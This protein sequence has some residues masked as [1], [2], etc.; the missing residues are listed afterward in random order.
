MCNRPA[1]LDR[2]EDLL[3]LGMAAQRGFG[4]DQHIVAPDL[5]ATTARW[6]QNQLIDLV[7]VALQ[8]LVRQPDG[9]GRVASTAAELD[10][11]LHV[12]LLCM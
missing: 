11:D 7:G 9:F 12:N 1:A 5:E 10:R 3:G 8:Y 2:L 6:D 4:K